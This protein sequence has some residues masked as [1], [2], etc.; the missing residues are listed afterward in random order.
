M[1]FGGGGRSS[2]PNIHPA[3]YALDQSHTAVEKTVEPAGNKTTSGGMVEQTPPSDP[4][5]ALS[6]QAGVNYRSI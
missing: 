3:P 2:N 6:Q 4:N 1:C 5:P